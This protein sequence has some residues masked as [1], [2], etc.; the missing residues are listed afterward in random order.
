MRSL[1][2]VAG[3]M[4]GCD[5]VWRVPALVVIRDYGREFVVIDFFSLVRAI[6]HERGVGEHQATLVLRVMAWC[7]SWDLNQ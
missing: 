5:V 1:R 6:F 4:A 3:G 7:R 2:G